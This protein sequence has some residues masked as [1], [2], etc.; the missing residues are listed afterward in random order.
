MSIKASVRG[1][2]VKDAEEA[3]IGEKTALKFTVASNR[4]R[5][6]KD[7]ERDTDFVDVLYF[8]TALKPYL[9][10]GK[11]VIVDGELE[12]SPW[13]TKDGSVRPGL[14]VVA[15]TIDLGPKEEQAAQE[16]PQRPYAPQAAQQPTPQPSAQQ[17]PNVSDYSD[18]LPF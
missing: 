3:P 4:S 5:K 1:R 18:Q 6:R 13:T 16:A 14:S 9:T 11:Y 8:R 15:D 10:K 2:L 17:A 12:A 7:G